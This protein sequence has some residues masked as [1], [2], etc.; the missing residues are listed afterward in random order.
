MNMGD[1]SDLSFAAQSEV[2]NAGLC[3]VP[4]GAVAA[5]IGAYSW[6][7]KGVVEG[8]CDGTVFCC[9]PTALATGLPVYVD[10][11]W[12]LTRDRNNLTGYG[13]LDSSSDGASSSKNA[14]TLRTQWN[15]RMGRIIAVA[16]ARLLLVL[17]QGLDALHSLCYDRAVSASS[18]AIHA[19]ERSLDVYRCFPNPKGINDQHPVW[20]EVA[21]TV[22]ELLCNRHA[23]EWNAFLSRDEHPSK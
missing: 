6:K 4:H 11:R 12:E 13:Q 9:L 20:H 17:T 3:L 16:Y 14:T 23:K 8:E 2:L 18:T 1:E 19:V 15:L 22:Y 10:G 5:G 7:A 21:R